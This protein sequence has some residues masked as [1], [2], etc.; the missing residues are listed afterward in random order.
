M[1]NLWL[2]IASLAGTLFIVVAVAFVFTNRANAPVA[3][4]DQATVLGEARNSK[5]KS[6]AEITV[7]EFSDFQCPACRAVQPLLK[8]IEQSRGESVRL[9]YRHFPL[10]SIHPNA[11]SA[12]KAAEAAANQE[13]FWEYH[14]LLFEKQSE[15]EKENAPRERFI[16][17]A[18][19]LGLDVDRFAK[20]FD[21]EEI[22]KRIEEDERDGNTLSISGTP[23]VYVNNRK[24]DIRNLSSVIEEL[25]P[26]Q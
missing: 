10:R 4:S 6:D 13:K 18:K 7:V 23:S 25:I 1:K 16:S 14:D 26:K 5:G 19:D 9:V 2:L 8:E 17:Y 3:P 24:T 21:G 22:L 12:A 15:W 11:V 20:D